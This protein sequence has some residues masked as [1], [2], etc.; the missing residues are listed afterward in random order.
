MEGTTTTLKIS[1]GVVTLMRFGTVNAQFIFEE[2]QKH[3]SYYDTQYGTF[4][5]KVTARSVLI[6]LTIRA[7]KLRLIINLK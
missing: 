7:E 2:G 4:T 1:D 6:M 3:V 5:M